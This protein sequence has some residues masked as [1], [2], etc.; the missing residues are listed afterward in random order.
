MLDVVAD[1]DNF[2][3]TSS[4]GDRTAIQRT[5]ILVPLEFTPVRRK[6]FWIGHDDGECIICAYGTLFVGDVAADFLQ[7]QVKCC[8]YE[9]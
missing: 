8:S 6:D 7:L 2:N 3:T 1:K 5:E 4:H 9:C